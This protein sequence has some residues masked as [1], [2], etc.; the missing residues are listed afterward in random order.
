MN[1][2]S[3]TCTGR[4]RLR[5]ARCAR[6]TAAGGDSLLPAIRAM[7]PRLFLEP[8]AYASV[9]FDVDDS[10]CTAAGSS[11]SEVISS[12]SLRR[13]G[14]ALRGDDAAATPNRDDKVRVTELSGRPLEPAALSEVMP[15]P[16][17][18]RGPGPF[19]V[20]GRLQRA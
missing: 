18:R 2:R 1:R 8:G 13:R 17:R 19:G 4:K 12:T 15:T 9:R 14:T 7:D 3:R 5:G 16:P 11:S 6:G 10:G 20:L